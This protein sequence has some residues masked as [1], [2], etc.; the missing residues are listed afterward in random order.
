VRHSL[1]N[2]VVTPLNPSAFLGEAVGVYTMLYTNDFPYLYQRGSVFYFNRRVPSDLQRHY[3]CERIVISLRTRSIKA[4]RVKSASLTSQ[5]DEEWLTLRWKKQETP[6][7]RFL[8]DEGSANSNAPSLSQAKDIYLSAKGADKPK[9]FHQTVERSVKNVTSIVGD[10]P[11]DLYTRKHANLVRDSLLDRGLSP[12][13]I[14]RMFGALAALLNFV[15]KEEGCANTSAFSGVYLREDQRMPSQKRQPI[16]NETILAVQSECETIDDQA[17]WLVALISD[18]G[19]RLSEAVGLVKADIRLNEEFPHI[20][21]RTH[22]WRRLKT[23]ASERLVPLVGYAAWA[24][25]RA[26]RESGSDFLFPKYCSEDG[27]KSNSASAALNKWLSPRVPNGCV[28][29]SFRHSFRDRL[30]AVECSRDI[31]DRLGGWAVNGIGQSYGAGYP[32]NVLHE[33]MSKAI[34]HGENTP[35]QLHLEKRLDSMV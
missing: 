10:R 30:R 15:S 26:V 4:A 32:I 29:H 17:R 9:T 11:I 16:P 6:L 23:E 33:W 2:T 22:P 24:A 27:C 25:A 21:L 5:L 7:A 13:S 12:S 8:L 14:R 19:M 3:R 18:T 1:L 28:I 20:M 31:A 35:Q 34:C